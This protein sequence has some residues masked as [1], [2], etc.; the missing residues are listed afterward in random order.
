MG[1]TI[2]I[3]GLLL[4][5]SLSVTNGD[6]ASWVQNIYRQSSGSNKPL[7]I[8]QDRGSS[9]NDPSSYNS[10][11]SQLYSKSRSQNT[12]NE[13]DDNQ[14]QERQ[15]KYRNSYNDQRLQNKFRSLVNLLGS[16]N[17]QHDHEPRIHSV[18]HEDL[19]L[20]PTNKHDI[21]HSS[22]IERV[23]YHGDNIQ[24]NYD[25]YN[26]RQDR[27]REKH[28]DSR[29]GSNK[30]LENRL[31]KSILELLSRQSINQDD[32]YNRLDRYDHE[33]RLVHDKYGMYDHRHRHGAPDTNRYVHQHIGR[34]SVAQQT[35]Q[36]S[37][38][39]KSLLRIAT[40][41]RCGAQDKCKDKCNEEPKCENKCE[42]KFE[43]EE[44]DPCETGSCEEEN[45]STRG[46]LYEPGPDTGCKRCK[47]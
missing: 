46:I 12:Y 5:F 37:P 31:L 13:E 6:L 10:L 35:D 24:D 47:K 38:V 19:S 4:V 9:W 15:K 2:R 28:Q 26:D 27:Y 30:S 1:P 32:R 43:C 22:E 41:I 29:T 8:L 21:Y 20:V 42:K 33:E 45:P 25:R 7:V 39:V 36:R 14:R 11:I 16:Q 44:P 17:H 40:S 23:G 34:A 18:I 3:V